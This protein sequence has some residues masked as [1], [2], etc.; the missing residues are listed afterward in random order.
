M[1]GQNVMHAMA[2]VSFWAALPHLWGDV[3]G[4]G[5]PSLNPLSDSLA[6]SS[7]L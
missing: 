3:L 2:I 5:S 1:V 4:E 7:D 6:C